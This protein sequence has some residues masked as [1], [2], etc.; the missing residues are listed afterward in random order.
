MIIVLAILICRAIALT[1][2]RLAN[3]KNT[4]LRTYLFYRRPVFVRHRLIAENCI[5]N[6]Y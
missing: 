1:I 6:E 5:I 2:Y 4:K 3:Y